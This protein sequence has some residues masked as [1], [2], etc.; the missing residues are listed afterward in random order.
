MKAQR[1]VKFVKNSNRKIMCHLID[2]ILNVCIDEINEKYSLI[3]IK[4]DTVSQA[5]KRVRI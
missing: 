2:E 5:Q 3:D 4:I 1:V